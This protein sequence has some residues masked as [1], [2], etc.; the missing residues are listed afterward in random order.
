MVRHPSAEAAHASARRLVAKYGPKFAV[1]LDDMGVPGFTHPYAVVS[2]AGSVTAQPLT[3]AERLAEEAKARREVLAAGPRPA[4]DDYDGPTA[5]ADFAEAF[6]R[7]S[8]RAK[9]AAKPGPCGCE[10]CRGEFCGGCG[11]AGCGRR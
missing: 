11:H 2:F 8:A 5:D 4:P 9:A 3:F 1:E 7:A 6:A 10:C